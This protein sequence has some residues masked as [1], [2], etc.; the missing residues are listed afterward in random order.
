MKNYF[1]LNHNPDAKDLK[2]LAHKTGLT[3]R[4]SGA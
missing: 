1:N 3:K 4:V 2:Q